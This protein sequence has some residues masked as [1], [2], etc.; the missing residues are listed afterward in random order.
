MKKTVLLLLAIISFT[1]Y[2]QDFTFGKVSKAEL[3]ESQHPIIEDAEAAY[4]LKSRKTYFDKDSYKGFLL[5]NEHHERIKVYN[6]KG[7]RYA[8][9]TIPYYYGTLALEHLAYN[10]NGKYAK[11]KDKVVD[12]EAYTYNIENGEVVKIKLGEDRIK[13]AK[14][15]FKN[16][17]AKVIALEDVKPGSVIEIRYKTISSLDYQMKDIQ[18][19]FDIPVNK[20]DYTIISP[21]YFK[22]NLSYLNAYEPSEIKTEKITHNFLVPAGRVPTP[23]LNMQQFVMGSSTMVKKEY[24]YEREVRKY[25]KVEKNR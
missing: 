4:L 24:A 20:L 17:R 1:G 11:I 7:V 25:T 10:K 15:Q 5:V 6:E 23:V 2:A 16:F 8:R 13:S 18:M 14:H 21:E 12:I 9:K 22:E 19:D 3:E